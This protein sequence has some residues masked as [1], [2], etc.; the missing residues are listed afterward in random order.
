MSTSYPVKLSVVLLSYNQKAFFREALESVLAQQTDF[1]FEIVVCD[2][3]STD[4]SVEMLQEYA[5]RHP[6]LIRPIYREKN[7]GQY[8]NYVDAHNQARGEYVAHLDGDDLF[9]PGKL[10]RQVDFL[11]AHPDVSIV[12]HAVR[13]IDDQAR[14]IGKICVRDAIA[15]DGYLLLEDALEIGTVG[16][17]S[18]TMYRASA[19]KTARPPV[20]P[21]DWF[22]AVEYLASGKGY[23][24]AET[25]GVYRK[26]EGVSMSSN[27]ASARRVRRNLAQMILHYIDAFPA[28]RKRLFTLSLL[29]TLCDAQARSSTIVALLRPLWASRSLLSPPAFLN[30]LAR[31]R[32]VSRA[33]RGLPE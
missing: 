14:P 21:I 24:L 17:H 16:V 7:L 27:S 25:L 20:N 11:D 22:Y 26:L 28:H 4:G 10:Q 6:R 2:D 33:F 8:W 30:A 5:Q 1:P 15:P 13:L 19:R 9:L 31:F 3:A 23:Q 29:Y 12:W 32:A 18:A